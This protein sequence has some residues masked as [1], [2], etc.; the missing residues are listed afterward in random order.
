[1]VHR[2]IPRRGKKGVYIDPQDL[3]NVSLVAGRLAT[4][5]VA[6]SVWKGSVPRDVEQDHTRSAL[7][8]E[9]LALVEAVL[10]ESL[11][12]EAYSAVGI[13]LSI[14]KRAHQKCGWGLE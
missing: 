2:H 11:R 8:P 4:R 5:W 1:M 14:L 13:G 6:P 7:T 12:K 10:P 3:I 9:E